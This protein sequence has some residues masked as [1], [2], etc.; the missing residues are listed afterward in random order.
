MQH[1]NRRAPRLLLSR[2]SVLL[3]LLVLLF[4]LT[5][6]Q[7]IQGAIPRDVKVELDQRL[8]PA[9]R[10][11][12]LDVVVFSGA[13]IVNQVGGTVNA[14][15]DEYLA[16]QGIEALGVVLA[17]SR[18]NLLVQNKVVRPAATKK[19]LLVTVPHFKSEVEKVISG[20]LRPVIMNAD[21]D[22]AVEPT[23]LG[24]FESALWDL[25]VYKNDLANLGRTAEM[26][27]RTIQLVLQNARLSATE[28]KTLSFDF[29]SVRQ[30][31]GV[32]IEK[33]LRLD[34]SLRERRIELALGILEDS[35]SFKERLQAAFALDQDVKVMRAFVEQQG[36]GNFAGVPTPKLRELEGAVAIVQ[37]TH[38]ELF[39]SANQLYTGLHW[40]LRGRYGKGIAANGLLKG[41][42]VKKIPASGFALSMPRDRVQANDP[43]VVKNELASPYVGR[44]HEYVWSWENGGIKVEYGTRSVVAESQYFH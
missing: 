20:E 5:A 30:S 8:I 14:E 44:R 13:M 37:G 24:E 36:K 23:K 25:H 3:V 17:R 31:V 7:Q 6:V 21:G 41:E 10:T 1:I 12:N 4:D 42:H 40:W 29:Q 33:R 22:A 9:Y 11:G 19:E 15:I 34:L 43:F 2:F 28:R 32:E 39:R 38:Q 18:F 27:G 26:A 35:I 16:G